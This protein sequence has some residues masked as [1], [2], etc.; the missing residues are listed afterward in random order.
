MRARGWPFRATKPPVISSRL[1]LW[2]SGNRYAS[3]FPEPAA[4]SRQS[5]SEPARLRTCLRREYDRARAEQFGY[6]HPLNACR[7]SNLC[8]MGSRILPMERIGLPCTVYLH[9]MQRLR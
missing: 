5:P 4:L 8:K 3:V 2:I 9:C 1:S 7:F 6:C